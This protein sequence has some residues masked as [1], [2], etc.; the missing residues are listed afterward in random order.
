MSCKRI[1]TF[2]Q[3]A[4]APADFVR[5]QTDEDAHVVASVDREKRYSGMGTH[6]QFCD[7]LSK[8]TRDG[9]RCV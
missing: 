1:S 5:D 6:M 8:F 2:A 4:E 7:E 3:L 9:V